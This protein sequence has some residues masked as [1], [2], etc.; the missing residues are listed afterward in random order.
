MPDKAELYTESLWHPALRW[1]QMFSGGNSAAKATRRAASA[2]A[3]CGYALR[4]L[5]TSNSTANNNLASFVGKPLG[6]ARRDEG[7]CD[8]GCYLAL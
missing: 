6:M 2:L 4:V 5:E 7:K 1:R 3:V 8:K